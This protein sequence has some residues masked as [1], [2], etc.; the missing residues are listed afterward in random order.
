MACRL[1]C[2]ARREVVPFLLEAEQIGGHAGNRL[3]R[4]RLEAGGRGAECVHQLRRLLVQFAQLRL[5][6]AR[7]AGQVY[8]PVQQPFADRIVPRREARPRDPRAERIGALEQGIDLFRSQLLAHRLHLQQGVHQ[9]V[10][11]RSRLGS[12]LPLPARHD[13]SVLGGEAAQQIP[14]GPANPAQVRGQLGPWFERNPAL[15][16]HA[17]RVNLQRGGDRLRVGEGARQAIPRPADDLQG[18]LGIR[19]AGAHPDEHRAHEEAH[20]VLQLVLPGGQLD[21]RDD[22]TA[23]QQVPRPLQQPAGQLA[24]ALEGAAKV[25]AF[26]GE[27]RHA[28]AGGREVV[29]GPEVMQQD[30]LAEWAGFPP[31]PSA[32]G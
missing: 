23:G 17:A 9:R 16:E 5:S 15:E 20:P 19:F 22:L 30:T 24:P 7:R 26:A 11:L 2:A 29:L 28:A 14:F 25:G 32:A 31:R 13:G 6:F 3:A 8:A 4:P 21:V 27:N 1:G 10:A 12:L 18:H